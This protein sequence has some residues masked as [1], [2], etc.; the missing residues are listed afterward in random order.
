MVA[1]SCNTM[2]SFE[3]NKNKGLKLWKNYPNEGTCRIEIGELI[4]MK[5][6]EDG[7]I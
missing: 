1:L 2:V 4:F 5:P 6:S 3:G 7:K